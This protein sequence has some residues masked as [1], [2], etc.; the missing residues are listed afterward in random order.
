MAGFD[1]AV[2]NAVQTER[3]VE[4]TT[5][6]RKTGAPSRRITWVYGAD[7]RIFVRSGRG[8]TRDWPKNLLANERAILHVAGLDVPVRAV[9]VT[10]LAESRLAGAFAQAKYGAEFI[11]VSSEGEE[12]FP[13]ETTTFELLPAG[14]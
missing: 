9:H 8:F 12:P 3:E 10:D 5:Y 13:G 11:D 14:E 2:T 7:G 4:L 6:G 1:P